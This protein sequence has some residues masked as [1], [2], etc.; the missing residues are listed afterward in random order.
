MSESRNFFARKFVVVLDFGGDR[1]YDI[2]LCFSGP[3]S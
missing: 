3:Y 1:N 2:S